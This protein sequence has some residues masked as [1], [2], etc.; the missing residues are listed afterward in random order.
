MRPRSMNRMAAL[1]D[2]SVKRAEKVVEARQ[3]I[4][5]ISQE[6]SREL[7]DLQKRP[8][9]KLLVER[10]DLEFQTELREWLGGDPRDEARNVQCHARL[11]QLRR[12]R[13]WIVQE[14]ADGETERE[15]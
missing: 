11:N 13:Q 9:G 4:E 2:L 14:E 15:R 12:W 5:E 7:R 6:Q 1:R 3:R 8:G 10:M